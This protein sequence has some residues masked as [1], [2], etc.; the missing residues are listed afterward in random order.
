MQKLLGLG[1]TQAEVI[2][3]GRRRAALDRPD[4]MSLARPVRLHRLNP[5]RPL[6]PRHCVPLN[7]ECEPCVAEHRPAA[8]RSAP[9]SCPSASPGTIFSYPDTPATRIAHQRRITIFLSL[10]GQRNRRAR[11]QI[12]LTVGLP[13]RCGQWTGYATVTAC[14]L[15]GGGAS[16][17]P[18]RAAASC[19]PVEASPEP[20]QLVPARRPRPGASR[21]P[22]R[23]FPRPP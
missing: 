17:V 10:T 16:R 15:L 22:H 18:H 21:Q 11:E 8:P 5:N 3:A 12:G 9:L 1:E 20:P 6:F 2:Q 13:H 19:R 4:L 7:Q 23:S 14:K